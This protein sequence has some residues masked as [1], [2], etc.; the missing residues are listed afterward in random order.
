MRVEKDLKFRKHF[1]RR[2]KTDKWFR[3]KLPLYGTGTEMALQLQ[4]SS[5]N[6]DQGKIWHFSF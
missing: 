4:K 1:V 2:A 6:P 5:W 3:S